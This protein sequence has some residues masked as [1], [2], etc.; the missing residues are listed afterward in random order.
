MGIAVRSKLLPLANPNVEVRGGSLDAWPTY[1]ANGQGVIDVYNGAYDT[2]SGVWLGATNPS[3]TAATAYD[4]AAPQTALQGLTTRDRTLAFGI[5]LTM[6]SNP[7][8][9]FL[10]PGNVYF[11]VIEANELLAT[12]NS[13]SLSAIAGENTARNLVAARKGF[14][15]TAEQLRSMPGGAVIG[16]SPDGTALAFSDTYSLTAGTAGTEINNNSGAISTYSAQIISS[17]ASMVVACY[18]FAAGEQV[19]ATIRHHIEYF[20][21][22][23][24]SFLVQEIC[25]P[26]VVKREAAVS[27]LSR[28]NDLKMGRTGM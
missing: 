17:P 1:W 28:H 25:L 11:L 19:C 27:A 15:V 7:A 10:P 13:L 24:A 5:N 26:S 3:T 2:T 18:G 20:P 12:M 21:D 22:S 6:T 23:A 4:Y 16:S 14:K 9:S 8:N